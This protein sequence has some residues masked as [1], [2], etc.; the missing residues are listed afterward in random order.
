MQ[1]TIPF[2]TVDDVR[3]EIDFLL[4]YCAYDGGFILRA[5]NAVSF[6]CPIENVVAFYETARDY[7]LSGLPDEPPVD[8][9]DSPPCMSVPVGG[10]QPSRN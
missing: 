8:I 7:D 5:S 9:P 1:R 6:D 4:R 10:N 2:G 3:R